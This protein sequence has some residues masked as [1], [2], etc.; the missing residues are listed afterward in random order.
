MTKKGLLDVGMMLKYRK[1]HRG[2][3]VRKTRKSK[4]IICDIVDKKI[5]KTEKRKKGESSLKLDYYLKLPYDWLFVKQQLDIMRN[6]MIKNLP[7]DKNENHL[8]QIGFSIQILENLSDHLKDAFSRL[9]KK[10]TR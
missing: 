1:P 3:A 10:E 5:D 9:E 2:R 7:L 4:I 6:V 8:G